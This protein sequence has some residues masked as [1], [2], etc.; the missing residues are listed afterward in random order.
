MTAEAGQ[1]YAS[2]DTLDLCLRD[3]RYFQIC[4]LIPIGSGSTRDAAP[5]VPSDGDVLIDARILT[6]LT[7]P[8]SPLF[9]YLSSSSNCF[10]GSVILAR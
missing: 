3:D 5:D 7:V 1:D 10:K 2:S 8:Q 6:A 4:P 9:H